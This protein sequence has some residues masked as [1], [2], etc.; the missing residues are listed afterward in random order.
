MQA[1]SSSPVVRVSD[2]AAAERAAIRT[3]AALRD[4]SGIGASSTGLRLSSRDIGSTY[5]FDKGRCPDLIV[6]AVADWYD[7][8]HPHRLSHRLTSVYWHAVLWEMVHDYLL[9][10]MGIDDLDLTFWPGHHANPIHCFDPRPFPYEVVHVTWDEVFARTI[11][12]LNR[13]A[14]QQPSHQSAREADTDEDAA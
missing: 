8:E 10:A 14:A 13:V 1:Q 6:A 7:D 4:L 5:G 9:P 2:K 11:H 12:L 3:L